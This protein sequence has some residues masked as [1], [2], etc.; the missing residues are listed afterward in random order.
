[1]EGYH[2]FLED[3]TEVEDEEYFSSIP[4]Q[5]LLIV[6]DIPNL[7]YSGKILKLI[8]YN[9]SKH[10]YSASIVA[11]HYDQM[12]RFQKIVLSSIH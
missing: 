2:I 3:G 5:S 9:Y 11:L 8:K 10:F 7:V 4:S 1:M 6:S 12:L